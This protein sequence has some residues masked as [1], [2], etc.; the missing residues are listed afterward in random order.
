MQN[1]AINLAADLSPSAR[2]AIEGILGRS[3]GDDEHVSVHSF[4]SHPAPMGEARRAAALRLKA[5]MD[6]KALPVSP[7]EFDAAVDEAMNHVRP[8]RA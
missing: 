4:S 8:R 5:A 6:A 1:I 3:V 7:E 2:A